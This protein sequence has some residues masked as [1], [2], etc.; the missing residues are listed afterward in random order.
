MAQNSQ[1]P[2][3]SNDSE[4]PLKIENDPNISSNTLSSDQISDANTSFPNPYS[5][6]NYPAFPSPSQPNTFIPNQP[7]TFPENAVDPAYVQSLYIENLQLRYQ[8]LSNQQALFYQNAGNYNPYRP[9]YPGPIFIPPRHPTGFPQMPPT[10]SFGPPNNSQDFQAQIFSEASKTYEHSLR[11]DNSVSEKNHNFQQPHFFAAGKRRISLQEHFAFQGCIYLLGGLKYKGNPIKDVKRYI[12]AMDVWSPVAPMFYP[13]MNFGA[14]NHKEYIFAAGGQ[15][16]LDQECS[17]T[18]EVL[19]IFTNRWTILPEMS[20]KRC[21]IG[22]ANVN[23]NIYVAGGVSI[24]NE[25]ES[26]LNNLDVFYPGPDTWIALSPMKYERIGCKLVANQ[27]VIYAL[28][29][30]GNPLSPY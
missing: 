26:S 9:C 25:V 18:F 24:N 11:S 17:R 3:S 29:G 12:P 8:I 10:H 7:Q 15:N 1:D 14:V 13:R 22:V 21:K 27:K 28:G 6:P 16:N 5:N 30:H 2:K 4:E 19:N 23:G 20:L